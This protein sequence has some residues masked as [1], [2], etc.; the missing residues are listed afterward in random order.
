MKTI[1]FLVVAMLIATIS[2]T[3]AVS[4]DL[5]HKD[6]TTWNVMD[7][8]GL[9]EYT[10]PYTGEVMN[11]IFTIVEPSNML[12]D[13]EY[14]LLF[15]TRN[16]ESVSWDNTG[17]EV[18]NNQSSKIIKCGTTN[19]VGYFAPITGTFDFNLYGTGLDY[20]DDGDDYDGSVEGAK[21]WLVPKTD[22]T[23]T[24]TGEDIVDAVTGWSN[25]NNFLWETELISCTDSST[26][27]INVIVNSPVGF[28]LSPL[29]YNYGSVFPNECSDTNPNGVITLTNTGNVALQIQTITTGMF[30]NIDYA[31]IVD[32]WI[33]ANSFSVDIDGGTSK[34]IDTRICI[35]SDATPKSYGG[36]VTFEYIAVSP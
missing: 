11:Y 31:E 10:M 34:D 2:V 29:T 28:E 3:S 14:C 16:A 5:V 9:L 32:S 7:S 21:V 23:T 33:D 6:T 25:K 17:N 8:A 22:I 20:I 27:T 24:G 4:V 35:P 19:G 13:T 1:G 30:E 26:Q 36:T 12:A 15:Y 18:W